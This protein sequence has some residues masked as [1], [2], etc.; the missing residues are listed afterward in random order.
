MTFDPPHT[1]DCELSCGMCRTERCACRGPRRA[2]RCHTCVLHLLLVIDGSAHA[3]R[4]VLP[5]KRECG[6]E[7]TG[8]WSATIFIFGGGSGATSVGAIDDE[9]RG[10][11][12]RPRSMGGGPR[13][14]KEP[15]PRGGALP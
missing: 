2:R 13:A 3:S 15:P 1:S 5:L 4:S 6:R 10:H 12:G 9:R 11:H 14:R 8:R 7:T